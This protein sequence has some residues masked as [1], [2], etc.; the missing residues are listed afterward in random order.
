VDSSVD[1]TQ[2]IFGKHTENQNTAEHAAIK[3]KQ[4]LSKF[5]DL[6]VADTFSHTYEPY[7]F[8]DQFTRV[9]GRYGYYRNVFD[10]AYEKDF[11][12]RISAKLGYGND[13]D[14][15]GRSDLFESYVNRVS[16]QG[17][18][19]FNSE[20]EILGTYE[21][22]H[23]KLDPGGDANTN[24]LSAGLRQYFT[25]QLSLEGMAGV[26]FIDSYDDEGYVN[27]LWTVT[28][29]D[30]VT[31]KE[32]ASLS[33][34]QQYSTNPSTEDIF[35]SWRISG[36]INSQL[37]KRLFG[38]ASVFYGR[39]EYVLSDIKDNL[40]GGYVALSYDIYKDFKGYLSY[41]YSQTIS[42]VD[43]RDYKK[44]VVSLKVSKEF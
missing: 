40:I 12:E 2:Q 13:L 27:P 1:V 21:F 18:Y 7:N 26:N 35:K 41:T 29:V 31:E 4:A 10:I 25:E 16:L 11:T 34:S 20:S 33:F 38:S 28:L 19:R 14:L 15:T 42:N 37:L 17:N 43:A 24:T 6:I 36:G 8:E 3:L 32:S 39:G 30:R 23:R 5:D 9:S 22:L 44:N